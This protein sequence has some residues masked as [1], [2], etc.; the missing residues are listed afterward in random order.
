MSVKAFCGMPV[1][2]MSDD[3]RAHA[4]QMMS[5][6]ELDTAGAALDGAIL[7]ILPI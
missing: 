2:A 1:E 5:E 7:L 3:E 6:A 4:V